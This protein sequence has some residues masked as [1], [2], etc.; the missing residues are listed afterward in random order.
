MPDENS[1]ASSV[2]LVREC[3][4]EGC[5]EPVLSKCKNC[6]LEY[7]LDHASEVD[8]ENY[9]ATCLVPEDASFTEKPLVD[10]EGVQHKGRVITPVGKAYRLSSKLVF[11]MTEQ[12]LKDFINHEKQVVHD[13][14]NVREYHMATLGLAESEAYRREISTIAKV[15]GVLRFGTST[16]KVPPIRHR[17]T[18]EEKRTKAT[19]KASANKVDDVVANLKALGMKPEDLVALLK[20]LPS[21]KK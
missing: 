20:A 17:A 13:I 21:K 6:L 14:E 4:F 12:E 18:P 19:A 2:E 10:S 8:P 9:C 3:T 5:K 1:E 15:G 16:Q 11:E 7:C